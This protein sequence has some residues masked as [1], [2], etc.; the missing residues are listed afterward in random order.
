MTECESRPHAGFIWAYLVFIIHQTLQFRSVGTTAT[1]HLDLITDGSVVCSFQDTIDLRRRMG[2]A[3]FLGL[4]IIQH[5]GC[6]AAVLL[7]ITSPASQQ[8][9]HTHLSLAWSI[10]S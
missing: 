5:E 3:V 7:L 9:T 10:P 1:C 4:A 8:E 2:D 6:Q